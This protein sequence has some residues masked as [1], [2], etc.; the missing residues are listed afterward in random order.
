MAY[1]TKSVSL[2]EIV[3]KEPECIWFVQLGCWWT[4]RAEDVRKHPEKGYPCDPR[5]HQA[6]MLR[7]ASHVKEWFRQMRLKARQGDFGKYGLAAFIAAHHSNCQVSETDTRPTCL[8]NW[9]QYNQQI[10]AQ[11]T[12]PAPPQILNADLTLGAYQE[13][14]VEQDFNPSIMER[15]NEQ[16]VVMDDDE[17]GADDE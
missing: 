17:D 1:I 15:D 11:A 14:Q 10:D 12:A 13:K 2:D 7:P 6:Q 9:R 5:G 3:A 8:D 4:H 16:E